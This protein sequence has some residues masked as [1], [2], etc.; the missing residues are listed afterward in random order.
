MSRITYEQRS[1][2]N[3]IQAYLI[4][5]GYTGI[6]Y[7]DG[8]QPEGTINPPHITVTF[9]PSGPKT[10]QMGRISG[11]D[12][13]YQRTIVVNAY[14]EDERRAQAIVDDIMDF[15]ELT[16]IDI[17]DHLNVSLGYLLCSDEE[18][19]LGQVFPPIMANPLTQRWRAS[20]TAPFEAFYP[21]S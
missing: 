6:T 20:V 12:S 14:M 19:I 11:Q 18:A 8:Y 9:P 13:L 1:T 16:C 21:N 2:L 3:A 7:T 10:L 15:L 4:S 17:K 5:K